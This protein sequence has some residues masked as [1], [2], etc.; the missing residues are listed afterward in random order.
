MKQRFLAL[1]LSGALTLSLLSACGGGQPGE[2]AP[3]LPPQSAAPAPVETDP[4][5]DTPLP[6]QTPAPTET[7]AGDV[8]VPGQNPPE[9]AAPAPKPQPTKTPAPTPAGGNSTPAPVLPEETADV[10]QDV[11]DRI[12][13]EVELPTFADMDDELLS[14]L[15][16]IDSADLEGYIGKI[17][18][19]NVQA[20]EIFIALVKEGAMDAVKAGVEKRQADLEAQ[21]SSYLPE[22]LELVQNYQLVTSGNYLLFAVSY[23]A[24]QL[25]QIF[26]D[27]T[28]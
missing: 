2:D 14:V 19:M 23:D 7:P 26:N 12:E 17:P 24:G 6:A 16:G 13:A 20:S 11:W 3:S 22:Q 8:D 1:A 25:V 4:P 9:S 21:W 18:L 28:N 15:Y 10:V 5:L 27:C